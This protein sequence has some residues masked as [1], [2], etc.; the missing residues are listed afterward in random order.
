MANEVFD[1]FRAQHETYL[2]LL[3]EARVTFDKEADL[4]IISFR[5]QTA[6]AVPPL[7]LK[8]LRIDLRH[9]D[10]SIQETVKVDWTDVESSTVV[11]T[12]PRP[13]TLLPD[14]EVARTGENLLPVADVILHAGYT[15]HTR[16][17]ANATSRQLFRERPTR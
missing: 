8:W 6:G 17:L 9:D 4:F 15:G 10:L 7:W 13:R 5:F 12:C 16:T 1:I 14:E 11:A 3:T 2:G